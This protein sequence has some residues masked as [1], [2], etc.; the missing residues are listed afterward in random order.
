MMIL[1]KNF[2]K[3][4]VLNVVLKKQLLK[5]SN[6]MRVL[7]TKLEWFVLNAYQKFPKIKKGVLKSKVDL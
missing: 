2:T 1:I 4:S 3:Q 6:G 7:F 5:I